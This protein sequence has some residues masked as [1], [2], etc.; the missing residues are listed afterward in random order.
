LIYIP[1]NLLDSQF[2]RLDVDTRT[3]F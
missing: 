2:W 3:E 1:L